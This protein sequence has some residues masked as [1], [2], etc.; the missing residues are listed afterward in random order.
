[1]PPKQPFSAQRAQEFG[2]LAVAVATDS[3]RREGL[4]AAPALTC[5]Y[6]GIATS[7]GGVEVA[8]P[9]VARSILVYEW[10]VTGENFEETH[11][12]KVWA[13]NAAKRGVPFPDTW[14]TALKCLDTSPLVDSALEAARSESD[15]AEVDCRFLGAARATALAEPG[16][17]RPVATV[18]VETSG[19]RMAYILCSWVREGAWL[20]HRGTFDDCGCLDKYNLFDE[21]SLV[22]S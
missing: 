22:N 1:M 11:R 8:G 2:D 7:D 19:T 5:S 9:I 21:R 3:F 16:D 6:R 4:D 12:K 14:T 18:M 13:R 17:I 10:R 20:C 15:V